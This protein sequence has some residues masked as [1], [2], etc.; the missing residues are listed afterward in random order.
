MVFQVGG[1]KKGGMPVTVEK[2]PKGKVVTIVSNVRGDK[3]G[4]VIEN[5]LSADATLNLLLR[6][7]RARLYEHA[8][9]NYPVSHAPTSVRVLFSTALL[10]LLLPA[11]LHERAP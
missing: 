4:V 6:L 3:A 8:P 9:C 5:K 10:R 1:T 7:L 2:R 11:R